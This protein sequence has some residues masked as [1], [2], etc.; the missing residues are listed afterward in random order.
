MDT[1]AFTYAP[2]SNQMHGYY[3]PTPGGTGTFYH[4]KAGDLHTP[5]MG[6]HLGTPLSM[7]NSEGHSHPA[8]A[9]DMHGFHPHVLQSH[10]FN[11]GNHFHPQQSYAPSSFVHQDSGFD[12]TI[13]SNDNTPEQ[14]KDID[15]AVTLSSRIL[16]PDLPVPNVAPN[17]RSECAISPY[18]KVFAHN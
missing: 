17:N 12:T 3:T 11:T 13:L 6:F 15:K 8:T 14:A 16:N 9:L 1:T 4:N 2:F 7:P 5:D 18:K 10:G